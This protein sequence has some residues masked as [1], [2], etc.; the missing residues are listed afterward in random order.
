MSRRIPAIVS[1]IDG[2]IVRGGVMIRGSKTVLDN[3][4]NKQFYFSKEKQ[5]K[6]KFPFVCLTNGGG[7]LEMDKANELNQI[8]NDP[9]INLTKENIILNYTPLRDVILKD[10]TSKP[11]LILG[12]GR[13]L[14]ISS[15][16]GFTLYVTIF[17]YAAYMRG[18]FLTF[19]EREEKSS[20]IETLM[21]RYNINNK[22]VR[23]KMNEA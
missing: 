18:H 10:W 1:D 5:N 12:H 17:E 11:V 14:D 16:C 6:F 13:I 4:L 23:F 9:I 20:T 3:L 19:R 7:K 22:I 15:D 2:V 8:I 21:E